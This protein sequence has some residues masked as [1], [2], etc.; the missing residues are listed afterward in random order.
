MKVR[1]RSWHRRDTRIIAAGF[2]DRCRELGADMVSLPGKRL[3]YLSPT[4]A[5]ID[6]ILETPSKGR[7]DGSRGDCAAAGTEAA[8]RLRLH[9]TTT[10]V[11][12]TR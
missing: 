5:D 6:E 1:A 2:V 4:P 9:S 10:R 8:G 11:F 3:T 12:E 7:A